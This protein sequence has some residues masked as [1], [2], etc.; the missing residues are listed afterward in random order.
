M[1]LRASRH[2]WPLGTRRVGETTA[3]IRSWGVETCP[4]LC[5]QFPIRLCADLGLATPPTQ[6]LI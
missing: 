1:F 5:R 3:A 6:S 4:C 2:P